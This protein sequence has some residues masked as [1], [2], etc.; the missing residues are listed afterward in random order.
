MPKD[1]HIYDNKYRCYECETYHELKY[2]IHGKKNYCGICK[3]KNS[4]RMKP[5]RK[6]S[7]D[8]REHYNEKYI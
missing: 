3:V 5:H 7:E 4:V 2:L 1:Y 6:K 8:T